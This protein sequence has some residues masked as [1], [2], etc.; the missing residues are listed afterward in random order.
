M[1][2]IYPGRK[3][4]LVLDLSAAAISLLYAFFSTIAAEVL[5]THLLIFISSVITLPPYS[6]YY[7]GRCFFGLKS[8]LRRLSDSDMIE[9]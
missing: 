2:D 9:I 1:L 6:L 3:E 7:Q 5:Y 4:P 8:C